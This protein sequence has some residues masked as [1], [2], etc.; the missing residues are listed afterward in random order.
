[1]L[2]AMWRIDACRNIAVTSRYQPPWATSGPYSTQW[3]QRLPPFGS[4]NP[5][6]CTA[7]TR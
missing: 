1:M 4:F 5:L 6:P 2:N 3:S 7:V